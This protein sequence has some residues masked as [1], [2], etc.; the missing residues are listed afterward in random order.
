MEYKKLLTAIIDLVSPEV[1]DFNEH[2]GEDAYDLTM[3]VAGEFMNLATTIPARAWCEDWVERYLASVKPYVD[4]ALEAGS[5]YDQIFENVYENEFGPN[6]RIASEAEGRARHLRD[7]T[8]EEY[9]KVQCLADIY[10]TFR[11]MDPYADDIFA[12]PVNF[13]ELTKT[14]LFVARNTEHDNSNWDALLAGVP[15]NDVLAI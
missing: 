15:V 3:E 9:Y 10:D 13:E 8:P 2:K 11:Y 12:E 6:S 7:K 5:T 4:A 14:V 1:V